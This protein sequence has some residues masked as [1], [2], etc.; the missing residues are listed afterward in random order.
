MGHVA[1]AK[2]YEVLSSAS[3]SVFPSFSEC[4]A[5]AP[6]E[7]MAVGCP[8]IY[9][10]RSSG[11]ELITDGVDGWL[12][13]PDDV[14]ALAE[15]IINVLRFPE[16][17]AEAGNAGQITV[18]EKFNIRNIARLHVQAYQEVMSEYQKR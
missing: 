12:A 7:A 15:K 3:V 6:M 4:F 18:G 10:T 5:L 8:V 17:G 16:I 13:D 1:R 9:T 14:N 11:S 2:L